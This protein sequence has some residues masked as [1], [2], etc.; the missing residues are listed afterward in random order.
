MES[1]QQ[2]ATV[3]LAAVPQHWQGMLHPT[4]SLTSKQDKEQP[5]LNSWLAVCVTNV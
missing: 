3:V 4:S 1:R 2:A 5:F